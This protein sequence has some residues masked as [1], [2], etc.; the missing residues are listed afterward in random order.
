[1]ADQPVSRRTDRRVALTHYADY[2]ER[3]GK[4]YLRT[5]CGVLIK[6]R[7]HQNAPTCTICRQVLAARD[8][9]GA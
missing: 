1:M 4:W 6:R 7:D 2:D 3:V 9:A 5:L 8:E